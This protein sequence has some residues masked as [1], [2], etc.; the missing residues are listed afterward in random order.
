[1]TNMHRKFNA[2]MIRADRMASSLL[3]DKEGIHKPIVKDVS[4]LCLI[5]CLMTVEVATDNAIHY[6]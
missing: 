3:E 1:M 5:L 4:F 2:V 6:Y